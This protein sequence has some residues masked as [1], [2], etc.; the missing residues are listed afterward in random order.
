LCLTNCIDDST[1]TIL[2]DE[3]QLYTSAGEQCDVTHLKLLIHKVE[4]NKEMQYHVYTD[5]SPNWTY[6]W[7]EKKKHY[8]QI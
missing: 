6:T 8:Y 3:E 5:S 1:K 4:V 2:T 7:S